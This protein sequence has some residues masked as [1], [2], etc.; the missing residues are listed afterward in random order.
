MGK[1]WNETVQAIEKVGEK[2]WKSNG[3]C[4]FFRIY[5]TNSFEPYILS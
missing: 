1:E 5:T 2:N 4:F 3:S